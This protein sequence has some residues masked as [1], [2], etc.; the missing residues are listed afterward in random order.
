MGIAQYL[1]TKIL[2]V[3]HMRKP[4]NLKNPCYRPLPGYVGRMDSSSEATGGSIW[5]EI[6]DA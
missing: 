2:L 3:K 4:G 6:T 5:P 1:S